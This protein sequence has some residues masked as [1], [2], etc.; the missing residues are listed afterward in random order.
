[1]S[2]KYINNNAYIT[3]GYVLNSIYDRLVVGS[4]ATIGGFGLVLNSYGH[5]DNYG[6]IHGRSQPSH[7]QLATSGVELKAGGL[8]LNAYSGTISGA[9]GVYLDI[10]GEVENN[11]EI[12]GVRSGVAATGY[13][14]IFNAGTIRAA[15][16][17][18]RTAGAG[19]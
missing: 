4:S 8:V 1:M 2:T 3:T 13:S 17:M 10:G 14:K 15:A 19:R 18:T 7:H 5:V 9:A 11:G 16:R 12:N 6:D